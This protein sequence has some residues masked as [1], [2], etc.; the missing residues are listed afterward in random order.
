MTHIVVHVRGLV[1]GPYTP[2]SKH[3]VSLETYQS[4]RR[5]KSYGIL[6]VVMAA[7]LEVCSSR[8][9]E[10][11]LCTRREGLWWEVVCISTHY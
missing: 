4:Q 9:E 1:A 2:A 8:R 10:Y 6:L 11:C 7:E 3:H 5:N